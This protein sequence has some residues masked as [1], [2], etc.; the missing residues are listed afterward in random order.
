[1]MLDMS[2]FPVNDRFDS[3]F[4]RYFNKKGIMA[5]VLNHRAKVI[6]RF[7]RRRIQ[8]K[9]AAKALIVKRFR[10]FV[11]RQQRVHLFATK[12]FIT[13]TQKK[14]V[15]AIERAYIRYRDRQRSTLVKPGNAKAQMINKEAILQKYR[16]H[17]EKVIKIQRYF[18]KRLA[19]R[20]SHGRKLVKRK[21]MFNRLMHDW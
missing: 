6:Q 5:F 10:F 7:F 16:D 4:S 1:M 17:I 18:R 3:L 21:E 19:S 20:F 11:A 12:L 9:L 2:Q 13:V 14:A 15:R 8:Y